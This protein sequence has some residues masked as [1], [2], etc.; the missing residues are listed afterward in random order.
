MNRSLTLAA[1]MLPVLFASGYACATRDTSVGDDAAAAHVG[2]HVAGADRAGDRSELRSRLDPCRAGDGRA[3]EQQPQ[4]RDRDGRAAVRS[5]HRRRPDA[6][7]PRARAGWI[8]R[9]GCRQRRGQGGPRRSRWLAD[10]VLRSHPRARPRA[11]YS[12]DR[13]ADVR[14]Q[15]HSRRGRHGW[16][17]RGRRRCRRRHYRRCEGRDHRRGDWRRRRDRGHRRQGHRAAGGLDRA[18]PDG[19]AG[20]RG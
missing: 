7:R 12:R 1:A 6:G 16:C 20:A 14:E 8:R 19:Y 5:D 17:R 9:A 10:P 13:D 18:H 2:S 4:L 3:F 15:G 11:R